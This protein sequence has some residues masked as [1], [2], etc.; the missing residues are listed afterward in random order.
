MSGE[1]DVSSEEKDARIVAMWKNIDIGGSFSGL[2]RFVRAMKKRGLRATRK[3]V[4]KALLTDPLYQTTRTLKKRFPRRPTLAFY[5][6]ERWE[7]DTGDIG[8]CRRS[9]RE[10]HATLEMRV[11]G[12]GF[13]GGGD[14][15]K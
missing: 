1:E 9:A 4:K 14:L 7:M 2:D 5:F 10:R 13:A 6:G 12:R 3:E 8:S 15:T 11:A